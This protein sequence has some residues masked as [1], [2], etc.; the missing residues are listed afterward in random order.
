MDRDLVVPY[1]ILPYGCGSSE[2]PLAHIVT[3]LPERR[4]ENC[5]F[6]WRERKDGSLIVNDGCFTSGH[7]H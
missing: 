1:A 4:K 5:L 2:K 3:A 7:R 6:Y